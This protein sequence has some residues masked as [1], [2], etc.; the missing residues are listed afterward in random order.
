[1]IEDWSNLLLS[2]GPSQ[3]LNSGYRIDTKESN[4]MNSKLPK[5]I[6]VDYATACNLRCP[7]CTVWGSG[8]DGK[9]SEVEGV[10]D[11]AKS[12]E[13]LTQ[14]LP[15]DIPLMQPNMYGEPLLVPDLI[16]RLSWLK[17]NGFPVAL[18]TNGL[19]LTQEIAEKFVEL[20]IDS[21]M[22]SID[23]V[24]AETLKKIRGV[25]AIAR[26]E[27]AVHRL[28]AARGDRSL[29]R[30]GV[31]F[32]IQEENE[33]ET[34]EFVKR[35]KGVVDVVR[36][37]LVFEN[38]TFPGMVVP[39]VRKPCPSLYD[40]MPIHNDGTVTICCLDGFKETAVG[41]VFQSGVEAI[42]NG[43]AFNKIREH[44]EKGDFDKV[45]FCKDCNGW[46]QFEMEEHIDGDILVRRS[47]QYT[48]YN[49]L[50]R[51]NNWAQQARG[52]HQVG[53]DQE[54]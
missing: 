1:M 19:T 16:D 46:A 50:S 33:H 23:A 4:K 38:G 30:I 48:Y 45:P 43:D 10:M 7:M 18:N 2:R 5:R 17:T 15:D 13:V 37:G 41:N 14:F 22:V 51:M 34:D 42:W 6:L 25:R 29:P 12:E 9:I 20:E 53:Y 36:T 47:P 35:W 40:T 21:V 24:S 54:P 52:S 49:L 28:L 44:H 26:I 8:D 3:S 27:A 32:T 11:V 31:S 39:E